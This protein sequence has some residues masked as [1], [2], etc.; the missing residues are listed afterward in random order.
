MGQFAAHSTF[1]KQI[2]VS[3]GNRQRIQRRCIGV[4]QYTGNIYS[5]AEVIHSNPRSLRFHRRRL[6]SP[7]LNR[8]NSF[9][10]EGKF[11]THICIY[12]FKQCLIS[13]RTSRPGLNQRDK[14]TTLRKSKSGFLMLDKE[15]SV[16]SRF[17]I[18]DP[19]HQKQ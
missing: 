16:K 13:I 19:L 17:Y 8:T 7:S 2:T 6:Q 1:Y 9:T 14:R 11:S 12:A 18:E 5:K 15:K 10:F 4:M 3:V